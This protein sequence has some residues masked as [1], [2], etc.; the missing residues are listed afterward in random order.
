MLEIVWLLVPLNSTVALLVENVP[1]FDQFPYTES[2]AFSLS[3]S[4]AVEAMEI[5]REKA[6]AIVETMGY[7]LALGIIA[8]KTLEGRLP[9][10]QLEGV[11]QSWLTEPFQV[12]SELM[13]KVAPLLNT[14][15]G[16]VPETNTV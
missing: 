2:E 14:G 12:L 7:W 11:N 9:Q 6:V 10:L 15:L 13:V 1:A 8:C 3:V 5:S 16:Q 4:E